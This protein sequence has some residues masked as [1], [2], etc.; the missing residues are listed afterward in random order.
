MDNSPPSFDELLQRITAEIGD[1][2]VDVEFIADARGKL[3]HAVRLKIQSYLASVA[4]IDSGTAPTCD[5]V[6]GEVRTPGSYPKRPPKATPIALEF[7]RVSAQELGRLIG[8][9]LGAAIEKSRDDMPPSSDMRVILAAIEDLKHTMTIQ[10]Q[11]LIAAFAQ[12]TEENIELKDDIAA[13]LADDVANRTKVSDAVAA[14]LKAEGADEDTIAS[15]LE[16]VNADLLNG[17]NAIRALIGADPVEGLP[18]GGTPD[19][20][21]I[22]PTSITGVAGVALEGQVT[23]PGSTGNLTWSFTDLPPDIA[24]DASGN[25]SGTPAAAEAGDAQASYTSDDGTTGE[26][27]FPYTITAADDAG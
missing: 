23:A 27:D 26:F 3:L 6:I 9:A 4:S 2:D 1:G 11:R 21:T 12:L 10:S 13:V 25:I 19:T 16:G 22:S 17:H 7:D 18:G 5:V 24:I 14:A 8:E 15:T 20:V